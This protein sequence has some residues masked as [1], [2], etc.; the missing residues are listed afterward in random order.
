[1]TEISM[2]LFCEELDGLFAKLRDKEAE[3]IAK[4]ARIVADSI[5]NDGVVHVFG[6]GHSYGFGLEVSDRAGSLAPVHNIASNDFVLYGKYSLAEFKD[7]NNI[8]E[9][10]PGI[11]GELYSL[12]E[13]H[14]Q[15]VF[16]IISN[17]GINGLVIDM[18]AKAKEEGHKVIVVTCWDHTSREK[19][20]HP[21]G[22]KLYEFGDVVID[23]CGPYGDA[24]L[25]TGGP[26]KIC[27][28]S[29]ITGAV[30]AQTL[31]L[32]AIA[33]IQEDGKDVPLFT[34]APEHDAVLREH[35]GRRIE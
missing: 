23:N 9:R 25:E 12:Y 21:S 14:P 2:D 4:A 20:R 28:V 17:S 11:A 3:N 35:Y 5:E 34:G 13:I 24:L 1:M 7:Q 19:S 32:D 31:M 18:A 15:D 22:K 29:S 10:R 27:S 6:S 16:I 8:F 33:D 26:E 30:I